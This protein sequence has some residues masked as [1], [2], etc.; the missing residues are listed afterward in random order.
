MR[1]WWPTCRR[2]RGVGWPS[3]RLRRGVGSLADED[4][5]VEGLAPVEGGPAGIVGEEG[6]RARTGRGER[7]HHEHAA[8]EQG[9][10]EAAKPAEHR[11]DREVGVEDHVEGV[12]V[13]EAGDRPQAEE[14]RG[15]GAAE[16][17]ERVAAADPATGGGDQAGDVREQ[18]AH[19]HGRGEEDERRDPEL[20]EDRPTEVGVRRGQR[21]EQ[22]RRGLQREGHRHH[23]RAQRREQ[24][25]R[26]AARPARERPRGVAL[27]DR[28]AERG[29]DQVDREDV[30]E[31]VDGV[32]EVL[33]QHLHADDLEADAREAGAEGDE[34]QQPRLAQQLAVGV[35]VDGD[36][37]L[38]GH[39]RRGR[40]GCPRGQVAVGQGGAVRRGRLGCPRGQVAAGQGGAVRRGRFGCPRGQVDADGPAARA[41][42]RGDAE[43]GRDRRAEGV[44]EARQHPVDG[45]QHAGGG[46]GG[47]GGVEAAEAAAVGLAAEGAAAGGGEGGQGRAEADRAGQEGE[48]GDQQAGEQRDRGVPGAEQR[49]EQRRD[50]AGQH[51]QQVRRDQREAGGDQLE[52]DEQAHG[53]GRDLGPAVQQ[54]GAEGHA[55]EEAGQGREH[56]DGLA[57]EGEAEEAGPQQLVAEGGGAGEEEG[58]EQ[59]AVGGRGVISHRLGHRGRRSIHAGRE[60][61]AHRGAISWGF[62][63]AGR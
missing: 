51:V 14:E 4:E 43:R 48:G 25:Q 35:A 32:L 53:V 21:G 45:Q 5:A 42:G 26:D 38:G 3:G 40:L 31:G 20:A 28:R 41:G 60:S 8:D 36:G 57:A 15:Q 34:V 62:S 61:C 63:L 30:G 29:A 49:P 12:G 39:V 47:V 19:D 27:V 9:R 18:G 13:A 7:D 58:E 23:Q 37:G 17:V 56:A 44:A 22:R 52:D 55:A 59:G 24:R 1:K 46:A 10:V 6:E 54:R 2:R 33:R 11:E 16:G 50:L